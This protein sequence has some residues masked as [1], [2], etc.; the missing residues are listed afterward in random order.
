MAKRIL[1]NKDEIVRQII[2]LYEDG[3]LDKEIAEML[4]VSSSFVQKY[5]VSC[6]L[7]ANKSAR[8]RQFANRIRSLRDYGYCS[9][10]IGE[11]L[12]VETNDVNEVA[13][14][15]G[16]EFDA[17]SRERS[18]RL[19]I[20]KMSSTIR[21]SEDKIARLVSERL[22]GFEYVG[23]YKNSESPF[24]V[25][26]LKC[27]DEFEIS[28]ITFRKKKPGETIRCL[29]CERIEKEKKRQEAESIKQGKL[30]IKANQI[31]GKQIKFKVCECCGALYVGENNKYC[32]EQCKRKSANRKKEKRINKTNTV[33][34]NITLE[35]LFKRDKGVCY[36]CGGKCD[37][38]DFK[39]VNGNFI[40][41]GTYPTVEHIFPLSRGGLH[42][43]SN[44]KLACFAC[45]TKKST[46]LLSG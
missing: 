45:N 9:V 46:N 13:K 2:P 10:E 8:Q 31:T 26:C 24:T 32:S 25:R 29:N 15:F 44:V 19:G 34:K 37:W 42:E 17:K 38:N 14:K 40:V 6:G 33:D 12:G 30:D 4:G 27:G 23:G 20:Q 36:L 22:P 35:K 7:L 21:R 28:G 11:M 5:R 43:W 3:L 1:E 18:A 16:I 39:I 41:G